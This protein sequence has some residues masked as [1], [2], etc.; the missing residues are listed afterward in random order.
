[1]R[2]E[3]KAPNVLFEVLDVFLGLCTL[4]LWLI[5]LAFSSFAFLVVE[6]PLISL[7]TVG[8]WL[9]VYWIMCGLWHTVMNRRRRDLLRIKRRSIVTRLCILVIAGVL[10]NVVGALTGLAEL[11]ILFMVGVLGPVYV[12]TRHLLLIYLDVQRERVHGGCSDDR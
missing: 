12:A 5:V 4:F 6:L 9:L 10:V 1:M 8:F 3:D 7:L 2:D 11:S